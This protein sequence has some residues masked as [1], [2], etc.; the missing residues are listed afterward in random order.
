M[1]EGFRAAG[2]ENTEPALVV[3][4]VVQV[5]HK[6]TANLRQP[7]FRDVWQSRKHTRM[8]TPITETQNPISEVSM[9]SDAK[10][11]NHNTVNRPSSRNKFRKALFETRSTERMKDQ[12]QQNQHASMRLNPKTQNNANA[13][14][15]V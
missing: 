6:V 5:V 1:V 14:M 3:L 11:D 4:V 2:V 9:F 12:C 8:L 7:T 13:N 15:N 10:T